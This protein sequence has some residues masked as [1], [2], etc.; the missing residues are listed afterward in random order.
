MTKPV[1]QVAGAERAEMY[2]ICPI[3]ALNA[4]KQLIISLE[5]SN[6]MYC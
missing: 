3:A 5:H 6:Y 4:N 1:R 2:H